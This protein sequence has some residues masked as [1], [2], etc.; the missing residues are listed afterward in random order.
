M[1]SN[2]VDPDQTPHH[3]AS[4]LGLH[5]LPMTDPFTC[6]HVMM[7]YFCYGNKVCSLR[8]WPF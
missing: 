5:C 7:A 4:D 2:I 1:L 6:F 3:V 8:V